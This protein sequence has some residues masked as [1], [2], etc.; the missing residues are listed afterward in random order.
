[1][2]RISWFSRRTRRAARRLPGAAATLSSVTG[3][4]G[5]A[6][7]DTGSWSHG[8]TAS[9]R[10]VLPDL[11]ACLY[12]AARALRALTSGQAKGLRSRLTARVM[13]ATN[14]HTGAAKMAT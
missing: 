8:P 7:Y 11:G 13:T 6:G 2:G 5:T 9:D 14:A 12:H 10:N 4:H 1:M 3:A